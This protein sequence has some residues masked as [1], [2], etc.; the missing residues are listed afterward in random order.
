ARMLVSLA[1][2]DFPRRNEI[3]LDW[4][5]VA[6]VIAM[7]LVLGVVAAALPAVWASRTSLST[8]I[9][10]GAV[11]GPG[12]SQRLRRG[13][14]VAQIALTLVLLSAGGLIARSFEQLLAADPG[15]RTSN[16]LTLRVAM[17]PRL[18]P[19]AEDAFLFQDRVHT[20]LRNLPGVRNV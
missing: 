7:G 5:V 11:R 16:L 19:N 13:T 3:A 8:L 14:V 4:S 15:F 1:P 2:L 18:F 6:L 17:D 20:A 12:G 9:A 10:T